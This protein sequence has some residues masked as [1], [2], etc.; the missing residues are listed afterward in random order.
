MNR[1][2]LPLDRV[3]LQLWAESPDP[4]RGPLFVR[5]TLAEIDR[6]ETLLRHHGIE[7]HSSAMIAAKSRETSQS[8]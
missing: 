4:L 6:L 3:L 5:W 7:P 2:L 1:P 8:G